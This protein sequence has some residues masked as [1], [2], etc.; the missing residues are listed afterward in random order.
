MYKNKALR[1]I[2]KQF[3]FA[4]ILLFYALFFCFSLI[5]AQNSSYIYTEFSTQNGLPSNENYCVFQDSKGYIWIGTDRGLVKYDGYTFETYTT[6]DGL[7]D[8]VIL[9]VTEDEK[10]NI[11]YVGLNNF[12]LGYITPKSE[13]ITK[14]VYELIRG[15]INNK[16]NSKH[17][18]IDTKSI[19]FNEIEVKN[20]TVHL[21]NGNYGSIKIYIN[22]VVESTFPFYPNKKQYFTTILNNKPTIYCYVSGVNR[23][24]LE[25]FILNNDTIVTNHFREKRY[26]KPSIACQNDSTFVY[27]GLYQYIF[28]NAQVKSKYLGRKEKVFKVRDDLFIFSSY[29]KT[30]QK[31]TVYVSQSANSTAPRSIIFDEIRLSSIML[32]NSGG[33]WLSTL[34]HGLKYLPNLT[35]TIIERN[36]LIYSIYPTQEDVLYEKGVKKKYFRKTKSGIVEEKKYA[37]QKAKLNQKQLFFGAILVSFEGSVF[38]EVGKGIAHNNQWYAKGLHNIND[39]IIYSWSHNKVLK[40]HK[41]S[42]ETFIHEIWRNENITGK[43]ESLFCLKEDSCLM[44]TETGIFKYYNQTI[45]PHE[46]KINKRIRDIFVNKTYKA[47]IFTVWGEGLY[48]YD[49]NKKLHHFTEENGLAGNTVNQISNTQNKYW[50]ATNKGVSVLR[51]NKK[52]TFNLK[53]VFTNSKVLS[54]PNVLQIVEKDSVLFL[55]TDN[56][57]NEVDLRELEQLKMENIPIYI[58]DFKVNNED[59]E[60]DN[61]T[62]ILNYEQNNIDIYY[63]GI[64]YKTFGNLEYRFRLNGLSEDWF[65]TKERKANFLNLEGKDYLFELQVKNDFGKWQS[66]SKMIS[67]KILTPYWKS[68]WFITLLSL[69]VIFVL[70]GVIYYYIR[71]IKNE[72]RLSD[73]KQ[74]LSEELNITRQKTL[75]AQLNPHF[76]FNSLNSIQNFILTNKPQLSSEYLSMFSKLMRYVFENSKQLYISIEDEIEAITLYL[77][78]EKLR[79]N[80]VFQYEIIN[81]LGESGNYSIPSLLVQPILENAIWHGLLS[82][83]HGDKKIYL[84]FS[85]TTT[86]ISIIVEDN[87]V[88]RAIQQK[89]MQKTV[90]RKQKSS[91]INLTR[92]RLNMLEYSSKLKTRFE[93][94]DLVDE[95]KQP[96]GTRVTIF[97]PKLKEI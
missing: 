90:I 64:S 66:N 85:E 89:K 88:G 37:L 15:N 92:E 48:I 45:E 20:D 58:D 50:I 63:T 67:F 39:S 74:I 2:C 83:K 18:I 69:M 79:H 81:E 82:K 44:A 56:G 95:N 68:W 11:W 54:S 27:D 5:K 59:V 30:S 53:T 10:G 73:E 61:N 72:K 9:N 91:G 55:G 17:K 32:D 35:S 31:E 77:E 96:S 49:N 13:F 19:H 8:N 47:I 76:I 46:I 60:F 21:V 75:N 14:D 86:C 51:F 26:C 22:D 94:E 65:Y 28:S 41:N 78:L 6:L 4:V 62:I 42:K 16:I 12:S 25:E 38:D 33:L 93:I 24:V 70:G 87:G 36:E 23:V 71:N 57:L 84:S 97:I 40:Y 43:L 3:N 52:G 29:S 34:K 1:I 7:A 80:Y